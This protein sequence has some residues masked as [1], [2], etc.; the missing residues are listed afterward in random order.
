M[1]V[2]AVRLLRA[3]LR[4]PWNIIIVQ[5]TCDSIKPLT[6]WCSEILLLLRFNLKVF[7]PLRSLRLYQFR[8]LR[9]TVFRLAFDLEYLL[10]NL[11]FLLPIGIIL[12]K[13]W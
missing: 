1:L 5:I 4:T 11:L 7:H 9:G 8:E 13:L 12:I 6:L 2:A 3:I 10:D